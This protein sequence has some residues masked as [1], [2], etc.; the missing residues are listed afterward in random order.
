[1]RVVVQRVREASVSV[2]GHV[3]SRIG[4]GLAVLVGIA[5]DDTADDGEW[6]A[7]KITDLRIFDDDSG[8]MNRSVRDTGGELLAVSQ[9]TLYASTRS[10]NRP[11][12]SR[13]A[14]S[15]LAKPRFDAFVDSLAARIGRPV[16]TGSFGANMAV[17]LIND[18]PV[19]LWL[20]S[21]VRD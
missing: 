15:D 6:L 2:D 16:A 3:V 19:T 8:V 4:A 10:G 17:A 21:R 13:A 18:G 5:I 14:R 7:R 11:S 9:F 1:M 12:W 20:D